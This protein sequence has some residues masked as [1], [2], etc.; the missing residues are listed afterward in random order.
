[1]TDTPMTEVNAPL[2]ADDLYRACARAYCDAKPSAHP[3]AI[4]HFEVFAASPRFRAAIDFAVRA[5]REQVAAELTASA[6]HYPP[7]VF[8]PD[9]T[10]RDAISGTAMR[11]A[12][13][14]AASIAEA[15][16]GD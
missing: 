15:T 6:E 10:S 7:D 2:P 5:G 13:T 12:Y 9:S 3:S 16:D 11:I 8:P 4:P 1:M 14:T